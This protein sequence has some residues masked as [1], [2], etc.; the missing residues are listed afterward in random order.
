MHWSTWSSARSPIATAS[1][2]SFR[3]TTPDGTFLVEQQA[4]YGVDNGRISWLRILCSGFR[5]IGDER[6]RA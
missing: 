4:Y 6:A 2:T 1:P 5:A 3:V